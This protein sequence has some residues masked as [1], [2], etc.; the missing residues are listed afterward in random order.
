[1]QEY[2]PFVQKGFIL[3]N[4]NFHYSRYEPRQ[5]I[6]KNITFQRALFF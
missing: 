1:M 6:K 4:Y 5:T 2:A 3:N